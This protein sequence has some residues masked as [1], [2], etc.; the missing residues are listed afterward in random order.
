MKKGRGVEPNWIRLFLFGSRSIFLKTP[1]AV[2]GKRAKFRVYIEKHEFFDRRDVVNKQVLIALLTLGLCV[3]L[4][5]LLS[6]CDFKNN[7]KSTNSTSVEKLDDVITIKHPDASDAPSFAQKETNSKTTLSATFS[8]NITG[9]NGNRISFDKNVTG[10]ESQ[11]KN[12]EEVNVTEIVPLPKKLLQ[13]LEKTRLSKR[14]FSTLCKDDLKTLDF[15]NR[16]RI[17]FGL[18]KLPILPTG[19]SADECLQLLN[20]QLAKKGL[21]ILS[22]MPTG[23]KLPENQQNK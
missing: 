21:S 17:D 14:D 20:A 1:C 13:P 18:E 11:N 15:I 22:E 6:N 4:F 8:E 9:V 19:L 3:I 2:K 16:R 10:K 5:F 7:T 12:P 23:L